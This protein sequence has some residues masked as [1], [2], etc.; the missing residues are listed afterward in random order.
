MPLCPQC[1][2]KRA[3][4]VVEEVQTDSTRLQIAGLVIGIFS[5]LHPLIMLGSLILNVRELRRGAGG[6]RRWMNVTGVALTCVAVLVWSIVLTVLLGK[7]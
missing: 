5:F 6:A 2:D 1:W 7:D 3:L 4:A